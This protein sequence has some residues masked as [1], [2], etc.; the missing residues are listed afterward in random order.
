MGEQ[1]LYKTFERISFA[2]RERALPDLRL[3]AIPK[4]GDK[5]RLL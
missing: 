1:F 3:P 4:M 2:N 5:D